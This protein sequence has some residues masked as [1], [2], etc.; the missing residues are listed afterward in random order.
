M[1]FCP[2]CGTR[3]ILKAQSKVSLY[4]PKCGYRSEFSGTKFLK[5]KSGNTKLS[6][7][8]IAILDSKVQ[9]LRTLPRV[10]VLCPKCEGRKAETWTLTMG[11]EDNSQAT[12]YR[13]VS[14]E[15]A[16]RETE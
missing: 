8:G 15:N 9:K 7:S 2:N 5:E 3:L 16:W 6:D 11:S 13:C 10:N 4:C 1:E 12:I 14:C